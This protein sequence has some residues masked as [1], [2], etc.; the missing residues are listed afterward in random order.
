MRRN[1]IYKQSYINFSFLTKEQSTAKLAYKLINA[2]AATENCCL[3][4]WMN[5]FNKSESVEG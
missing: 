4:N 5:V 1:Q 3:E 2:L